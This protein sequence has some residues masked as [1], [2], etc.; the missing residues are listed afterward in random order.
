MTS[1]NLQIKK[2]LAALI[3]ILGLMSPALAPSASA[4]SLF[5]PAKKDACAGAQLTVDS[6]PNCTEGARGTVGLTIRKAI[7]FITI[8]VGI[9]SVIMIIISGFRFITSNGDSARVTSAR[10]NLIYAIVGLVIVAFAQGIV[11]LV[12][13]NI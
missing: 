12:L 6:G 11:K 9:A 2:I 10:N 5:N 1:I 4:Q 3:I 7:D 13:I 8:I